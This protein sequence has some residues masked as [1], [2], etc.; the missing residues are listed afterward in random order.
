MKNISKEETKCL[1]R[2]VESAI[3]FRHDNYGVTINFHCPSHHVWVT[4]HKFLTDCNRKIADS[5][6]VFDFYYGKTKDKA[7]KK[8]T[9]K[10]IRVLNELETVENIKDISTKIPLTCGRFVDMDEFAGG[11]K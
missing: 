3:V 9:G 7:V 11:E 10:I 5:V 8:I 2:L 1:K 4:I 6:C